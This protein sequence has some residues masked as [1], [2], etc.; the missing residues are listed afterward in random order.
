[1]VERCV[2]QVPEL[3]RLCGAV[4]HTTY[5]HPLTVFTSGR[6]LVIFFL[7]VGSS[8]PLPELCS[9]LIS[10][11]LP[12]LLLKDRDVGLCSELGGEVAA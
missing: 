8:F 1:M 12:L 9:E 4:P 2:E 11:L 5:G 7:V 10:Q 6:I 3:G